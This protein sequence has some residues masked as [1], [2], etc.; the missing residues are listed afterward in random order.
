V[1][2]LAPTFALLVLVLVAV[3]RWRGLQRLAALRVRGAPLALGAAAAQLVSVVTQ[4]Q[5]AVLLV[6]STLL[7]LGFCWRNRRLA[8]VGLIA[9][10]IALN[11]LVML[12]NGGTMPVSPASLP[13]L[14]YE[15]TEG[16]QLPLQK[17]RVLA[18][19]HARL[20]WLGDRWHLPGPL[21]PVAAWSLGDGLLLAGLAWLLVRTMKGNVDDRDIWRAHTPP[22]LS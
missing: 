22:P 10:G 21:A 16:A 18:D 15:L 8:G 19:E 11:S 13:T 12:V 2:A 5:R 9:G 7:L 3:Y 20:A 4:Q 17:S 1:S 6:V 14:G